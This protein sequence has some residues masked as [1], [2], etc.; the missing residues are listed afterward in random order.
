MICTHCGS[1]TSKVVE[2]TIPAGTSKT[3]VS[4]YQCRGC[5]TV[6]AEKVE[7]DN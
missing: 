3:I 4:V 6:V 5:K 2:F 7:K 1:S